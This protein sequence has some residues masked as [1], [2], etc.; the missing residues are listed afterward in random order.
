M[1]GKKYYVLTPMCSGIS[2]GLKFLDVRD[3]VDAGEK[4]A[5]STKLS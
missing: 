3:V 5:A 1:T 4:I 2:C